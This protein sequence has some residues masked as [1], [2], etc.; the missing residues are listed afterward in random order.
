M[1]AFYFRALR[2]ITGI[3]AAYVSRTTNAEVLRVANQRANLK[4]GQK[5]KTITQIIKEKQVK[6]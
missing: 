3:K 1:D 5:L 6:L 4:Q 2:K